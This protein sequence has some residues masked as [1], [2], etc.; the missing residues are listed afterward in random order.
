LDKVEIIRQAKGVL[1]ALVAKCDY[2][3]IRGPAP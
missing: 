3:V 2:R 1:S